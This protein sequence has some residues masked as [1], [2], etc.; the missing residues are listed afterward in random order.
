MAVLNFSPPDAGRYL[1][2]AAV[3]A[4]AALLFAGSAHSDALT[5]V[6]VPIPPG[7]SLDILARVLAKEIGRTHGPAMIV[8]N[9][10]GADTIIGTEAVARAAPDGKTLAMVGTGFVINPLL[11]KTHYDP[12]TSFVPI[13]QLAT[14]PTV[15]AVSS[16]SPYL[17]LS[18]LFD[19][20]RAK[21]GQLTLGGIGPAST[22][23]LAF[24]KLKREAHVDMTFVP[25]PGT[26]PAFDAVLGQHVTAYFGE[27]SFVGAQV[28]ARNLRALAV[29][30]SARLKTMP[31][32]PTLAETGFSDINA[33]LWFAALAPAKTPKEITG[34]IA[35]LY[36]AALQVPDVKEKL[37]DLG[38]RPAAVCGADF[39]LFL[40]QQIE[41]YRNIIREAGIKA[42]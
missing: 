25:Y 42:E 32:V 20:A 29:A 37:N 13:C 26:A 11:R 31:D 38:L 4:V 33:E 12:V 18:D 10:P 21:P 1:C 9:R 39:A 14:L 6:I 35:S 30:S 5:K 41:Q 17:T 34:Q 7:A 19:D 28:K 36:A 16:Q 2:K 22:A 40:R 3:A 23:Q 27:A 24:E 8:E 15:I